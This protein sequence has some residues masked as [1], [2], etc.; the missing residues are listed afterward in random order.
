MEAINS[1]ML[2]FSRI[3]FKQVEIHY[4]REFILNIS[5]STLKLFLLKG[6]LESLTIVPMLLRV[7]LALFKRHAGSHC[8]SSTGHTVMTPPT[9]SKL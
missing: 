8:S 5:I 4:S 3:K 7:P 1:T 6:A 2:Y 9:T